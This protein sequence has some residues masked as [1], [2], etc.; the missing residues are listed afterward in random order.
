MGLVDALRK[1]RVPDLLL[2][3]LLT[4]PPIT[5]ATKHTFTTHSDARHL[6]GPI[7]APFGFLSGGVYNLTVF[8][9]EL[10]IGK[11]KRHTIAGEST[12]EA[13]E[14]VE[15]GFILK[16]FDSESDFS[17]FYETVSENP[18]A[19][20]FESHR[21]KGPV[22]PNADDD[23]LGVDDMFQVQFDNEENAS[24]N[25]G[26]FGVYLS[27][28]EPKQS[29]KPKTPSISH[30]FISEEEGLYFLIFQ[31]CPRVDK[32]INAEIRSSFELDLSYKN[33]DSFGYESYLTAGEMP[34]PVMFLYFSISYGLLFLL[35]ALN[36]RNIRL[37]KEQLWKSRANDAE[38]SGGRPVVH[39]IHHLMTMLLGLKA[40]TTFFEAARYHYIRVNGHAEFWS[41]VYFTMSFIKGTFM[42][43]VILL[44]GSGWSLVKPFLNDKEKKII[45]AVLV[46]QVVDN[47]AVVILTQET[48]GE[49]LY[50]DW[51][52]LLHL[53][54]ILC[55]CAVLIPIVWQVNSLEKSVDAQQTS[56][57]DERSHLKNESITGI[58]S[59]VPATAEAMRSIRKLKQFRSFYLL[60]V[61]YIY[62]TRIVVFLIATALGFRQTWLRYFITELGTLAFYTVVGFLFR[63]V[64]D[65]PYL[66]VGR[67]DLAHVEIEFGP[68]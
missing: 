7:G 68:R 43:T 67:N 47:I 4:A 9:F 23:Q 30:K 65:N 17:K 26:Q 16:R 38:S 21:N 1:G 37:G 10:T 31:L 19:C 56:Q 22:N 12:H 62:F 55:C 41:A 34:L 64:E 3:T 15:A 46:L 29:W 39:A 44:I 66:E 2:A 52:A 25:V 40:A 49:K 24:K 50:E 53:V 60:V 58:E 32:K 8:D 48:E 51:S 11:P 63:P 20:S 27:M 61:V 57:S 28:N 13:L 5:T 33:L 45:W 6:I 54:D 36:I 18:T 14:H 35:W 59:E 42:F